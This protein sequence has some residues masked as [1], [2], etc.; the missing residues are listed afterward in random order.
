MMD[1]VIAL[2]F[3]LGGF[4]IGVLVGIGLNELSRQLNPEQTSVIG[5]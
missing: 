2:L 3:L 4:L 1:V 5:D